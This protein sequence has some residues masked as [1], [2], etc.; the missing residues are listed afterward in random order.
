MKLFSLKTVK[1]SYKSLVIVLAQIQETN[2]QILNQNI[3]S[4]SLR[5]DSKCNYCIIT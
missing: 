2:F 3:V 4:T 5:G 1:I